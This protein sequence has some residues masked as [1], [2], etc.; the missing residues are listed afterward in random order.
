MFGKECVALRQ[1]LWVMLWIKFHF[2]ISPAGNASKSI[3]FFCSCIS[4]HRPI[5]TLFLGKVMMTI[6]QNCTF[7]FSSFDVTWPS[8]ISTSQ[9][10]GF[11]HLIYSPF[12]WQKCRLSGFIAVMVARYFPHF[13]YFSTCASMGIEAC[14]KFPAPWG[15]SKVPSTPWL[16]RSTLGVV[17]AQQL[18]LHAP[19]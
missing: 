17:S 12:K 6:S 2:V 9:Y 18:L 15:W 14:K 13:R 11:A 10:L 16:I 5:A 7:I 19:F 8:I 1:L 4:N 3:H